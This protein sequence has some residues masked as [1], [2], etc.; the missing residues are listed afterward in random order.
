[1]PLLWNNALSCFCS[2]FSHSFLPFLLLSCTSG[3][4]ATAVLLLSCCSVS[5]ASIMSI[6]SSDLSHLNWPFIASCSCNDLSL[7]FNPSCTVQV[8]SVSQ[9]HHAQLRRAYH[10]LFFIPSAF[11]LS[12]ISASGTLH[13]LQK[14][15]LAVWLTFI[16]FLKS[17]FLLHCIDV[18]RL[19]RTLTAF[20]GVR[21][22]KSTKVAWRGGSTED[23]WLYRWAERRNK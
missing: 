15:H 14:T 11:H 5:I 19:V 17:S 7:E 3:T 2:V 12:F 20:G 21:E 4:S 23:I 18:K 9:T 6:T 16:T 13:C 10:I 22:G 1:M 8:D